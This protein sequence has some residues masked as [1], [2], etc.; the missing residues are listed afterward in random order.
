MKKLLFFLYR[1]DRPRLRM[2]IIKRIKKSEGG[3]YYS[4]TLR[5][6]FREYHNVTV[7]KYSN[8]G[9]FVPNLFGSHTTVGRYCSIA[10]TAFV[11]NRDHP[12]DFKSIHPF[13]FNPSAGY[14]KTDLVGY[15]PLIIGN[16]VWIGHNAIIMPHVSTIGDGAVIGAGAV[17]HKDIPPYAIVVGNPAR[18]V[19][20]RFSPETIKKLLE[21]RWWEKDIE[22]LLPEIET[23]FGPYEKKDNRNT[24]PA[25]NEEQ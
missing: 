21:E 22:D 12:V 11:R 16:D 2:M 3:E 5:K 14:C 25:E 13:F 6:I 15:K 8:G 24:G 18:V 4:E 23:F 17:V 19:R 7:G 9:C 1:F 10:I 20:Y